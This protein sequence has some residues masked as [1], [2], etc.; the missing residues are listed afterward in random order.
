MSNAILRIL[1]DVQ[2]FIIS[3]NKKHEELLKTTLAIIKKLRLFPQKNILDIASLIKTS[4]LLITPDTSLVH[5]A[6]AFNK[7]V[8]GVYTN[9]QAI[10]NW[11]PL[12]VDSKALVADSMVENVKIDDIVSSTLELLGKPH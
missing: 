12:S 9:P 2:I 8:I 10:K 1:S 3:Y 11:G 5:V 4:D 7:K 6:S